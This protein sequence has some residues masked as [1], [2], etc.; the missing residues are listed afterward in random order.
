MSGCNSV[1][2]HIRRGDYL[3]YDYFQACTPE[4]YR[5]A[6]EFIISRVEKPLFFVFSDDLAWSGK[7]MEECGVE[8]RLV[9]HNRG[10]DSYKDM[11]LMSRCRHYII[12]NS[13][14]SWWGAWLGEDEGKTVA[15][16][17]EWFKGKTN[18]KCPAGWVRIK[19]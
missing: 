11:Y 4:Y 18:Y 7:F 13:S 5:R 1:S 2:V 19:V 10:K 16:P 8:Y 3:M 15:C 17:S 14:F 9:D 6:I 12:A